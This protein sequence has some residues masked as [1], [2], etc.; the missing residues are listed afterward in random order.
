[1][2]QGPKIEL[3]WQGSPESK[4]DARRGLDHLMDFWYRSRAP[5]STII[6]Y[7]ALQYGRHLDVVVALKEQSPSI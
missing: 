7:A 1:M 4:A 6:L 5:P 2:R 3:R